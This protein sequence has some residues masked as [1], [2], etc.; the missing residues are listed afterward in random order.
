[1]TPTEK[2]AIAVQSMWGKNTSWCH[3]LEALL[4]VI[5]NECESSPALDDVKKQV[6]KM[7]S[8]CRKMCV[9]YD[10]LRAFMARLEH[11]QGIEEPRFWPGEINESDMPVRC[12]FNKAE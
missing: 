2:L 3:H 11:E 4:L 9:G 12:G 1:M 6:E 7:Q 10:N 8:L 5:E